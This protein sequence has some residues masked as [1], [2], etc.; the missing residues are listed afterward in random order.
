MFRTVTIT[1]L[2]ASSI[3]AQADEWTLTAADESAATLVLDGT[4][5]LYPKRWCIL[6][7]V[8]N[9]RQFRA[10]TDPE[11]SFYFPSWLDQQALP[12]DPVGHTPF[13]EDRTSLLSRL[14]ALTSIRLMTLWRGRENALVIG[15]NRS[16]YLGISLDDAVANNE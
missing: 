13:D 16:G 2:F 9:S 6:T 14:E 5:S 3:A 11:L 8:E 1:L 10:S 12:T 4:T 15:L 7:Y